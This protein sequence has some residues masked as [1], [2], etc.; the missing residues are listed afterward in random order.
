MT[1]SQVE[2]WATD[3]EGRSFVG[4]G[5]VTWHATEREN[6]NVDFQP[7]GIHRWQINKSNGGFIGWTPYTY[8]KEDEDESGC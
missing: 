5:E 7:S 3:N 2:V 4:V 8:G 1:K 6:S